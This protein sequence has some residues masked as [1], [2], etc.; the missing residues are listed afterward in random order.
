M[1]TWFK[2]ISLI[3]NKEQFG[4]L[5]GM[6]VKQSNKILILVI[7]IA[8]ASMMKAIPWWVHLNDLK[9]FQIIEKG[10]ISIS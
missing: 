1:V 5:T 9:W 3:Y 2:L 4:R 6:R 10:W 8:T 7:P